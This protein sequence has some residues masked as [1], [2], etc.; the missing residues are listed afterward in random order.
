MNPAKV[1]VGPNF[2]EVS[3]FPFWLGSV[4]IPN[5]LSILVLNHLNDGTAT[6]NL[7]FKQGNL[8]RR[9]RIGIVCGLAIVVGNDFRSFAKLG[10]R[11]PFVFPAFLMLQIFGTQTLQGGLDILKLSV[12]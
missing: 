3:D 8:H 7:V 11:V 5:F 4:G 1:G 10:V 6:R 9:D 2:Y 12:A